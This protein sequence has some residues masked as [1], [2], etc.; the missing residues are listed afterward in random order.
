M[1]PLKASAAVA[2]TLALTSLAPASGAAPPVIQP[3]P[4]VKVLSTLTAKNVAGVPGEKKDFEATLT[5]KDKGTPLTNRQVSF[6]VTGKGGSSIPTPTGVYLV[7]RTLTDASGKATIPLKL[8]DWPQGS[9]AIKAVFGGDDATVASNDEATLAV[10][11]VVTTIELG[12]LIWGTYKNEPGAPYGTVGVSLMRTSDGTG[13]TK[14]LTITVNGHTWQLPSSV[15]H[16]VPLP[17]DATTWT[18]KVQY[19]GD[20]SS[21]A[22][23]AERTYTKPK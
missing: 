23:S 9:Y 21:L 5:V 7:G 19:A 13:M 22:S 20:T 18:V 16:Q 3:A 10:F 14:P 1:K 8:P 2:L 6:L 17:T 12:D 15:Y 4:Q 11:K